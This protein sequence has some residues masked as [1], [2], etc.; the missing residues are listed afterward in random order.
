MGV[1]ELVASRAPHLTDTHSALVIGIATFWQ[2]R[3]T[4]PI[5]CVEDPEPVALRPW[6]LPTHALQI[7]EVPQE[8]WF[9]L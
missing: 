5:R 1:L 7:N 4:R 3:A 8:C 6:S 9:A 2:A